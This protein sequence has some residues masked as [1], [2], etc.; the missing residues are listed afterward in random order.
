[1]FYFQIDNYSTLT[2][3][4]VGP[5]TVSDYTAAFTA[6]GCINNNFDNSAYW[7]AQSDYGLQ[8][9][10]NY[11]KYTRDGVASATQIDRCCGT[12]QTC[13]PTCVLQTEL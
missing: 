9:M 5:Y 4:M 13:T 7:S 8:D 2:F 11:C 1:M 10:M 3:F 12:G 6:T